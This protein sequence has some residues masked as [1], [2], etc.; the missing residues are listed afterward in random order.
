MN[1]PVK[2]L[3]EAAKKVLLQYAWPGNIRELENVIER[4]VILSKSEQ[5]HD[6]AL[7]SLQRNADENPS[8][9][10]HIKTITEN[11]R[12]HILAALEKCG[13]RLHGATGA[14]KML[15]IN[16]STLLSRMKKLGIKRAEID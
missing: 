15:D 12:E 13:W 5:I 4:S 1:K 14:A 8:L 9:G 2:G 11:Q 10:A 16:P 3:S 6:V 7:A